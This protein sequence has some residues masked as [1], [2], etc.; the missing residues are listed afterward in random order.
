MERF[1]QFLDALDTPGGHLFIL[2]GLTVGFAQ[3]RGTDSKEFLTGALSA[4]YLAM[5]GTVANGT[6]KEEKKDV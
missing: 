6:H 2:I 4:L 1:K 3:W 5:R